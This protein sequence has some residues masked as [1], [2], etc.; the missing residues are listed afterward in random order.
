[1]ND[2]ELLERRNGLIDDFVKLV[3]SN[4]ADRFV[5]VERFTRAREAAGG[6]FKSEEA[7]LTWLSLW[8]DA[9][10]VGT[11]AEASAHNPDRTAELEWLA[12]SLDVEQMHAAL[13]ATMRTIEAIRGYGNVRIAL[14]TLMLDLPQIAVP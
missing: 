2:P 8:R 12:T 7:L 9:L 5:Y 1:M 6:R 11:R 14:E 3:S 10:I 13:Q 4:R